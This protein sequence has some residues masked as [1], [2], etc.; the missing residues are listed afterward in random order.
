MLKR[1]L[2]FTTP[3]Q[4]SLKNSQLVI[5]IK[6]L[7]TETRT[8]PIE[9]IGM[10]IIENQM[11][12]V[13]LPLL[14]ELVDAG[15]A[16]VLCDRKGMPHAMLQNMDGHNLQGEFL[17]NQVEVGEVLRK[18]LWK[19][20]VEAKIKN[21]SALLEKI[22]KKGDLLKPHYMNVKSGDSDNREGIAARSYW[23]AMF[24]DD[25]ARDR[26]QPGINA[27]LNYGYTILR[28]ATARALVSAGLT[29][30]LGIFHHNR[31]NAFPLA[32]DLMEPYR[33]FVDEIVYHLCEEG[34]FELNKDTKG[35]LLGILSCDTYF[36]KVTRPLQIGL[37]ITMASLAKCYA[38]E[39][40]L[41]T[42]PMLK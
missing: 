20:I 31:S 40:K 29:P 30:S 2:V 5:S 19:Q 12:S 27:L 8:V 14:N 11:I 23:G 4:L 13:T 38:G 22:H 34:K 9:D 16:V 21:Q 35:E 3:L 36:P 32:D 1:T 42:L 7:P 41:L 6:E 37:S 15:V 33:P 26:E 17:R 10:V 24:G 28:A 18:Q 25:F 39:Q